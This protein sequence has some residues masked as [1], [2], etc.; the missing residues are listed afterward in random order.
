MR[1]ARM[2]DA[3]WRWCKKTHMRCLKWFAAVNFLIVSPR[4]S[5]NL[6]LSSGEQHL[7]RSRVVVVVFSKDPFLLIQ[8]HTYTTLENPTNPKP[9][10]SLLLVRPAVSFPPGLVVTPVVRWRIAI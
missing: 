6:L 3:I 2:S 7:A 8:T 5:S 9:V 4:C 1:R 10:W